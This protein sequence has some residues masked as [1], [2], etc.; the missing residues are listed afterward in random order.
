MN[1]GGVLD[2]CKSNG[3]APSGSPLEA[4]TTGNRENCG[5]QV[6]AISWSVADG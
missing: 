5:W 2:T 3:L 1:A 6:D 4:G